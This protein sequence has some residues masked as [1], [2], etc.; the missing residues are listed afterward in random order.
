MSLADWKKEYY[1]V[2]A[3]QATSTE[4]EAVEHAIKKWEGLKPIILKLHGLEKTLFELYEDEP[5]G[6]TM[7]IDGTTCALCKRHPL[8]CDHCVLSEVRD[9]A[10]CTMTKGRAIYS[11]YQSFT[12]RGDPEPMLRVLRAAKEYLERK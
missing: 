6:A 11:P 7:A 10:S 3:E 1:P 2:P 8:D 12:K 4:L 5:S 9:G